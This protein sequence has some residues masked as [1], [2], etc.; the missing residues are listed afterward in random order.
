MTFFVVNACGILFCILCAALVVVLLSLTKVF[1]RWVKSEEYAQETHEEKLME[2]REREEREEYK[3]DHAQYTQLMFH[4]MSRPDIGSMLRGIMKE[5]KEAIAD[6]KVRAEEIT[7]KKQA[8]RKVSA[9]KD[10]REVDAA[11]NS[12]PDSRLNGS[13]Q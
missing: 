10:L 9:E 7:E 4:H 3:R 12:D 5:A 6:A 13:I 2:T 1:D 11:S 8:E